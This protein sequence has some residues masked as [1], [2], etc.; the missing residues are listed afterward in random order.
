MN[1]CQQ[2]PDEYLNYWDTK[3]NLINYMYSYGY[4][5]CG[6]IILSILFSFQYKF[7]VFLVFVLT[8]LYSLISSFLLIIYRKKILI[9][10][11]NSNNQEN[12][13]EFEKNINTLEYSILIILYICI[14][15]LFFISYLGQI[16]MFIIMW[17]LSVFLLMFPYINIFKN[18]I[19]E[20]GEIIIVFNQLLINYNDFE[21]RQKWISKIHK[22]L[23]PFLKIAFIEVNLSN[24]VH[25]INMYMNKNDD[26]EI[27]NNMRDWLLSDYKNDKIINI[28]QTLIPENSIQPYY[29]TPSLKLVLSYLDKNK[30]YILAFLLLIL[31]YV[32]TQIYEQ[33]INFF[34]IIFT[35]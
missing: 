7:N 1:N 17:F 35:L 24:F 10:Y 31:Y 15:G 22:I 5:I 12:L 21:K 13:L 20:N 6:C 2:N 14:I 30:I 33:L 8:F 25:Q 19:S 23:L 9:K 18:M 34:K 32:N 26:N 28:V 4:S 29:Y 16:V 3:T 11:F 27:F